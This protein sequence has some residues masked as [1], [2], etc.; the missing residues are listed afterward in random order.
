MN[1]RPL[2]LLLASTV[3]A[4]SGCGNKGPLVLPQEPVLTEVP[5]SDAAAI[6]EAASDEA[7][8]DEAAT[9]AAA[10]DEAAADDATT[11]VEGSTTPPVDHE[12]VEPVEP[13]EPTPPEAPP[14]DDGGDG[15]G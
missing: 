4:L 1:T 12:P 14:A 11:P 7:G 9:D 2:V 6:E 10:T 13:V 3:L 8:T 15:N 5:E